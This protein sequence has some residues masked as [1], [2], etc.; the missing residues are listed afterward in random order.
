MQAR[1]EAMQKRPPSAAQLDYLAALGDRL[2]APES[3]AEASERIEQLRQKNALGG[4]S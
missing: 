2:G 4:K 1:L 3:M